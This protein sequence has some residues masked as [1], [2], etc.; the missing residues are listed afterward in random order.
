MTVKA[1]FAALVNALGLERSGQLVAIVGGGGKSSLMF[2]LAQAL[3]GL[4]ITTTTTR[5]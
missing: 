2:S 4:V 3:S 1:D 5:I